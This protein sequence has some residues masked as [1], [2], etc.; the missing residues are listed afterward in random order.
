MVDLF[1]S[2]KLFM[3]SRPY[4]AKKEKSGDGN[5]EEIKGGQSP[6]FKAKSDAKIEEKNAEIEEGAHYSPPL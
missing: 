2:L 3:I 1:V 4:F 5:P 6:L